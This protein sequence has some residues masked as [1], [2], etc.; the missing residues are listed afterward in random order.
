MLACIHAKHSLSLF[1]SDLF[2]GRCRVPKAI[3]LAQKA[4]AGYIFHIRI[5]VDVHFFEVLCTA[6]PFPQ[7]HV[8]VDNLVIDDSVFKGV[9]K[10]WI[11]GCCEVI[12]V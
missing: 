11:S 6:W 3:F 2:S 9:R 8:E 7:D 5:L 4:K 12:S 1:R 10:S